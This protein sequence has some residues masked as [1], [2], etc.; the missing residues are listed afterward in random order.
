[1]SE[2]KYFNIEK[3]SN[4]T[5][6]EFFVWRHKHPGNL[7]LHLISFIGTFSAIIVWAITK[8][9]WI[10]LYLPISSYIGYLGHII[11]KEGGARNKDLISPMTTI[12]LIK[13]FTLVLFRRY[14]Q[15]IEQVEIKLN[16]Q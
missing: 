10:A 14:S 16:T 5:E 8:N 11:Y 9:H 7:L 6:W 1:M 13:I 3:P 4:L 12:Y 2:K 15:V